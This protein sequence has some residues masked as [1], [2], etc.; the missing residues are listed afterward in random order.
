[1]GCVRSGSNAAAAA[2]AATVRP[3]S[4]ERSR[5]VLTIRSCGNATRD[6]DSAGTVRINGKVEGG[7]TS[8]T[9]TAASITTTAPSGMRVVIFNV[10]PAGP[11]V[12][13]AGIT[14]TNASGSF[15]HV[16]QSKSKLI[17]VVA[18]E[19][20]LTSRAVIYDRRWILYGDVYLPGVGRI[21]RLIAACMETLDRGSVSDQ[22]AF[23][24]GPSSPHARESRHRA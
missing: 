16:V 18:G 22:G 19:P 8:S 13:L 5:V 11:T 12:T 14:T 6:D 3:Q 7:P 10:E 2:A 1:M 15:T 9:T 17:A 21:G 4:S 23:G 20:E 24:W